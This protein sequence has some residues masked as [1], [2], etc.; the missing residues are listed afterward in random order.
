MISLLQYCK[1]QGEGTGCMH[2]WKMVEKRRIYTLPYENQEEPC[3][4][5]EAQRK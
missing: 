4:S 2:G 1:E 3:V 5:S